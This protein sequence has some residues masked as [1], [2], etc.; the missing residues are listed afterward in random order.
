MPNARFC[1]N[2]EKITKMRELDEA[3]A[4]DGGFKVTVSKGKKF[5]PL[6]DMNVASALKMEVVR[7]TA[8][9]DILKSKLEEAGISVN[10]CIIFF[11]I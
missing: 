6:E 5:Q 1:F 10:Y 9:N 7:L 8:Q 4:K 11:L 3:L 2:R